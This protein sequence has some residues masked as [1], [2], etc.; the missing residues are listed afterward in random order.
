[1]PTG[2]IMTRRISVAILGNMRLSFTRITFL[3]EGR[4]PAYELS[5]LL[6]FGPTQKIPGNCI[7]E[8]FIAIDR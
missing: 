3:D 6:K 2:E 5:Q 7:R 8:R 4:E 1:M